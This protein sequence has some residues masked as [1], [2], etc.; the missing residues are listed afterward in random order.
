MKRKLLLIHLTSLT[1]ITISLY[2][3]FHFDDSISFVSMLLYSVILVSGWI[4]Q[5]TLYFMKR[6]VLDKKKLTIELV[7]FFIIFTIWYIG[8]RI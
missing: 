3:S 4:L 8:K 5:T 7:V 1:V 6:D 2:L